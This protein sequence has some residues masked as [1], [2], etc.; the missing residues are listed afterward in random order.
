MTPG[1]ENTK[2][3]KNFFFGFVKNIFQK[4]RIR[5]GSVNRNKTNKYSSLEN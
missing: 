5:E 2:R 4:K 1:Y 3:D